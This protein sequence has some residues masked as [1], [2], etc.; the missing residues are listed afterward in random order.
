MLTRLPACLPVDSQDRLYLSVQ[1]GRNEEWT[2]RRAT[3][4]TLDP[5]V[6]GADWAPLGPRKFSAGYAASLALTISP[7]G[8]APYVAYLDWG[9]EDSGYKFPVTVQRY[10]A[11]ARTWQLVGPARFTAPAT[12]VGIAVGGDGRPVVGFEGDLFLPR[13]SVMRYNGTAWVHVGRGALNRWWQ[14]AYVAVDGSGA[15]LVLQ[16]QLLRLT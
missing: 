1:D 15:P 12:V 2:Q 3:V 6:P 4:L 5:S 11:A 13:G 14:S 8:D 7:V 16:N 9:S 10:N